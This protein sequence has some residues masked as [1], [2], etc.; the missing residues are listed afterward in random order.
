MTGRLTLGTA[1]VAAVL[2]AVAI[3]QP[4][5]P[6]RRDCTPRGAQVLARSAHAVAF[7]R[8]SSRTPT[9]RVCAPGTARRR[10]I[11]R[12]TSPL[13]VDLTGRWAAFA[14]IAPGA[15]TKA[16]SFIDIWHDPAGLP[17]PF[18]VEYA[19]DPSVSHAGGDGVGDHLA[20]PQV[21]VS[22][23]GVAAWLVCQPSRSRGSTLD[24]CGQ[25]TIRCVWVAQYETGREPSGLR[26]I[27]RGRN[28]LPF[29][30]LSPDQRHVFWYVKHGDGPLRAPLIRRNSDQVPP[31]RCT[32]PVG[33]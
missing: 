8:S 17:H 28:V 2:T 1:A 21:V 12:L 33:P 10:S 26:E 20:V 14:R 31:D 22:D 4:S 13:A 7:T 23:Q 19:S 24:R 5:A 11:G 32:T 3:A 27:A 29:I 25:S 18:T 9:A 15:E 30:R 16:A 6:G